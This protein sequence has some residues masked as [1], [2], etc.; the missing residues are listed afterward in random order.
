MIKNLAL[1][2]GIFFIPR[3]FIHFEVKKPLHLVNINSFWYQSLT[4][5]RELDLDMHY[6][7]IDTD[8]GENEFGDGASITF[9]EKIRNVFIPGNKYLLVTELYP[10]STQFSRNILR[11][12]RSEY[13]DFCFL[14]VTPL[15]HAELGNQTMNSLAEFN[16]DAR[17]CVINT[18]HFL[19]KLTEQKQGILVSEAFENL[20]SKISGK[21]GNYFVRIKTC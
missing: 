11:W 12:L 10:P 4:D 17:V 16:D 15:F 1:S 6:L 8:K 3:T 13:I 19:Q 7:T 5:F 2:T 20:E 14:G 18:D 9:S 21:L